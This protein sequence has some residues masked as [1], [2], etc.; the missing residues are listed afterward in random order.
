M[1]IGTH[2]ST[3]NAYS[4]FVKQKNTFRQKFL[5]FFAENL[6]MKTK[7]WPNMEKA[8]I[9]VGKERKAITS[10]CGLTSNAFSRGLERKSDPGA[11]T[12]YRLARAV[13]KTIEELIDD[14]AGVEYVRSI[15]R[16]DPRAIQVPD[17]ISSIVEDLLLLDEN[18][19]IGIRAN[20]EAL[21]EAKK[22]SGTGT[23]G[24]S[25]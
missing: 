6:L 20:V 4:H 10:E 14:E 15:I 17:R 2:K 13:H 19:L 22:G 3:I 16:N 23:D 1:P 12:A 24:L 25:G 11:G 21:A 18:E 7:F 8:R 5:V 9:A